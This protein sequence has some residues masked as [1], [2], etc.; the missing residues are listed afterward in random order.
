MTDV[1]T[2]LLD[3]V[4][5]QL[6]ITGIAVAVDLLI[7]FRGFWLP[8]IRAVPKKDRPYIFTGLADFAAKG[9]EQAEREHRMKERELGR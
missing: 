8:L 4:L 6:A 9:R 5:F 3:L 2:L 7:V 1:Q